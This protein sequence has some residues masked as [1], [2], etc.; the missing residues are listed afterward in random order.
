[1]LFLG[2]NF[3]FG[4]NGKE[5]V[6]EFSEID[7]LQY[8]KL[9]ENYSNKLVVDSTKQTIPDSSFTLIINNKNQQFSCKE[10]YNPCY[11]YN[12]FLPSINSFIIT[13][14]TIDICETFL[15]DKTSGESKTLFSP[16][17][18][19]SEVPLF[20]KNL[21]KML[22]FASN[23]FDTE[24]FI[25][26]YQRANEDEDFNFDSYE[27]LT[28]DKWKIYE[29]IWINENSFALMTFEKYGGISGSV[30]LNVN[31]MIGEMK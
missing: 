12:G 24:S 6:V 15:I 19:Q 13:Y 21:K 23:V 20:S 27:S 18:N 29:A 31:Y 17:D 28:T 26:I 14:C 9:K 5:F 16:Y 25:S 3:L 8:V 1:M 22:V 11:Y 30:P 7:S 4:Q 10:E 2:L